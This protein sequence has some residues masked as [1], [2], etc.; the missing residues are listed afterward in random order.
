MD[1]IGTGRGRKLC[2]SKYFR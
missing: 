2:S 1:K